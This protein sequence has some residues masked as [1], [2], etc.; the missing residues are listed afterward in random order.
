PRQSRRRMDRARQLSAHF[1]GLGCLGGDASDRS[2]RV[3]V[4][5]ASGGA[6]VR[7]CALAGQ[8]RPWPW[9]VDHD[10]IAADDAVA[11][12]CRDILELPVPAADRALQYDC[13]FLHRHRSQL[14]PDDR[15][16]TAGALG[17]RAGRYLDVD[18]LRDVDLPGRAQIH[19]RLHLRSRRNRP[20]LRL[21]AVLVDNGA[22]GAALLD[23][24]RAVPRDRELQDVRHGKPAHLRR[25][26]I[27]DRGGLDHV[28]ARGVREMAHR[29]LLR[30]RR[31]PLR[32][33]VRCGEHLCENPE[34]PEE[35]MS[36]TSAAAFSATQPSSWTRR[37]AGASVILY[38]LI[39]M[40]PLMRIV[41]TRSTHRA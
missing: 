17:D 35:P 20:R 14:L 11:G 6:G 28:E 19:S 16:C 12:G 33:C 15:R 1:V 23:V 27:D 26:G 21:A 36:A 39:S 30:I 31:Y 25:A 41:L 22:D 18:A 13:R 34:L 7:T 40:L 24:G 4:N 9:A 5:P 38:A 32:E 10:H 2:F 37:L 8:A 29:L 3:L